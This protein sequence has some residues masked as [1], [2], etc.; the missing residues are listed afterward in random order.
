VNANVLLVPEGGLPPDATLV[1]VLP[2]GSLIRY[3]DGIDG[4]VQFTPTMIGDHTIRVVSQEQKMLYET[5]LHVV[6]TI[7]EETTTG[8]ILRVSD[9]PYMN[10]WQMTFTITRPEE[11]T[12]MYIAMPSST[13]RYAGDFQ[14]PIIFTPGEAGTY[15]VAVMSENGS[16]VRFGFT[17][18]E[19]AATRVAAAARVVDAAGR[20]IGHTAVI[21][22][23]GARSEL[24][25]SFPQGP[26]S[27]L[28]FRNPIGNEVGVDTITKDVHVQGLAARKVFAIDPSGMNFTEGFADVV[29]D[30]T[31][32]WK[33]A[34]W[35]FSEQLCMGSWQSLGQIIP[36]QQYT[37][38]LSPQDPGYAE[39]GVATIK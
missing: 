37:I 32:L 7:Q 9:P 8:S 35:N 21:N 6:D 26:V 23:F 27:K 4:P 2:D 15:T 22:E 10:G 18:D 30:G 1:I 38:L 3:A 25:L 19:A 20:D 29:A 33:C 24:E 13:V 17:V 5:T 12:G 16:A 28:R 14:E 39:T 31:E 36:G 11:V 34:A